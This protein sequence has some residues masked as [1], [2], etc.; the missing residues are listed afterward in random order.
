M[1]GRAAEMFAANVFRPFSPSAFAETDGEAVAVRG[2][3]AGPAVVAG[4]PTADEVLEYTQTVLVY[5]VFRAFVDRELFD[6]NRAE[7]HVNRRFVNGLVQR[8]NS[9]DVTERLTV[10][11][12]VDRVWVTCSAARHH[13]LRAATVELADFAYGYVLRHNGV[14]ELLDFF[15]GTAGHAVVSEVRKA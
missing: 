7:P 6:S 15:A 1:Y 14:N 10:R 5:Q 13:V 2:G 9:G 4:E 11:D 3:G 12:I 8:L